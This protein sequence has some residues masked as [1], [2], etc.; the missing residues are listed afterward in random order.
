MVSKRVSCNGEASPYTGAPFQHGSNSS[1]ETQGSLR[2][3]SYIDGSKN[4]E[5]ALKFLCGKQA[6]RRFF[7]VSL[8]VYCFLRAWRETGN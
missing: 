4:L 8:L 5:G 2:W 1:L 3:Y 6:V 7:P